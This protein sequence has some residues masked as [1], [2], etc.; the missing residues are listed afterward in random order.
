[1]DVI[2]VIDLMGGEVVHARKGERAAYAPIQSRIATGSGPLAIVGALM[3]LAPFRRLYVADI[4]AIRGGRG[5]DGTIQAIQAA[6]PDVEIWVDRGETDVE[7]LTDR[8]ADGETSVIGTESFEDSRTLSH[9]LRA[10]GGVLSLDHD[11]AEPI[12][13]QEIHRDPSLWP[14]RVI[15]MTLARVGAGEGPDVARLA[16]IVAKAGGREVYAAGGVRGPADLAMLAAMGVAGALVASALHD[17]R[18]SPKELQAL[19]EA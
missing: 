5:H 12:G 8:R 6:H 11:A 4:D 14:R 2:P 3:G 10:S 15:V 1:M 17:G 19:L 9:A 16:E 18:I 7:S 13:P